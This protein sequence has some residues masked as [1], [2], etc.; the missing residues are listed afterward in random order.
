MVASLGTGRYRSLAMSALDSAREH[1][2]H[3]CRL[4]LHLIT[5]DVEGVSQLYN[6]SY[7]PYREW[8]ESGLSKFEDILATQ[9]KHLAEADYFYFIDG[10]VRFKEAVLLGDIS[11]D[12][13]GVE[14]PMYPRHD[15][16]FC[17]PSDPSTDGFCRCVPGLM[18]IPATQ[19]PMQAHHPFY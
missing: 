15:F 5:D 3:D 13:V 18:S 16:G 14:H 2:G 7:A 19:L 10:D 11:G 1:F 8:P 12:L 4:S 17:K 9:S 6:P